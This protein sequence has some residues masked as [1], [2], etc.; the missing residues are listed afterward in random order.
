MTNNFIPNCGAAAPIEISAL[1][2]RI[3]GFR[4]EPL[5]KAPVADLTADRL[6]FYYG[7][8]IMNRK[9]GLIGFRSFSGRLHPF[10]P[11]LILFSLVFPL[12]FIML[13]VILSISLSILSRAAP[14]Y[15]RA[16]VALSF[17]LAS[18]R[19]PPY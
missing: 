5:L 7:Y 11:F 9:A 18:P 17:D 4:R 10:L 1:E 14:F 16:P 15:D 19:S 6:L 2:S 12:P 13:P 8:T 3:S